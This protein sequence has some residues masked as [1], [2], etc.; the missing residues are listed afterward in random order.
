VKFLDEAQVRGSAGPGLSASSLS[1]LEDVRRLVE[2]TSAVSAEPLVE[3]IPQRTVSRLSDEA[4]ETSGSWTPDMSSWYRFQLPE[5]AGVA[6]ALELLRASPVVVSASRAPEAVAPPSTPDFSPSQLHLDPA[7]LGT[8]VEWAHANEPRALGAGIRIVD[9]EYYWTADHEDLQLPASTDL[10]G[11][12]YVQYRD[13]D[14][15]HGTAVFGIMVANDNGFGVTGG[16]P[17]ATMKGISPVEADS[18]YNPSGA[19]T[20][21]AT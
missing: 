20:L 9:L 1:W 21:L 4:T 10:G 16:V 11:G 15:E 7:P 14:D 19:L 18:S 2:D 5:G 13:F 8:D 3:G 6:R 17:D 12:A